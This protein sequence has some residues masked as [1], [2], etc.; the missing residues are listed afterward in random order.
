MYRPSQWERQS[1]EPRQPKQNKGMALTKSNKIYYDN[2]D[3]K[4]AKYAPPTLNHVD[5]GAVCNLILDKI[6]WMG[7]TVARKIP[8]KSKINSSKS[9]LLA[10]KMSQKP[11]IRKKIPRLAK[12]D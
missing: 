10:V 6:G 8:S 4:H 2:F 3:K 12:E 1:A 11:V 7:D 9:I 5:N